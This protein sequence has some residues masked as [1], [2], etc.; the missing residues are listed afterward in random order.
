MESFFQGIRSRELTGLQVRKRPYIGDKASDFAVC[1]ALEVEHNG[2]ETP[3]LAIS[4][5]KSS[6]NSHVLAVSDEDGYLSLFDTRK[7]FPP[8]ASQ[9]EYSDK[10]R[11]S[12]WE[13][14]QNAIFD[15]CW[16]KEDTNLL[17]ASGD[18]TIKV[19]DAQK[20]KCTGVLMGHTGSIKSIYCHPTNSD[21]LV[22][23]SRDG[24]FAMWDLRCKNAS[25]NRRTEACI[26]PT[27]M[28]RRAHLSPQSKRVRRKKAASMSIT[29]V[30]YLKDGIS[31]ATAGAVDSIVKFWD[32]RYLKAQVTQACPR[33]KSSTGKERRL[34]GTSSLSQDS[35][36]VF[37]T[38][39]CMDNSIYL[40]NVLQLEKGPVRSFSG[41]RIESFYVKSEISPDAAQL[42]SGSSD[43]NAYIWQVN[44]PDTDPVTLKT[45]DGEVTAVNWCPLDGKIAT[46]SDDFTVRIWNIQSNYFSNSRSSSSIRRRIMALPTEECR[47]LL[48]NEEQMGLAKTPCSL[49]P[50]D[51]VCYEIDS[52]NSITMPSVFLLVATGGH[53]LTSY[54]ID[55]EM[56]RKKPEIFL[57]DF[58]VQSTYS[59]M[60]SWV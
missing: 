36:G 60:S 13:A 43:G 57:V 44:K 6:K 2:E 59:T 34:H 32:T 12:D 22:S 31:I 14:H 9:Q 7:N 37:L 35:N 33:P 15:I 10:S 5:A 23:G 25:K 48:R 26:T 17:T 58:F 50:S 41:C 24:S 1:G 16:I 3:P 20:Q 29:S 42:L 49:H 8:Y 53:F 54:W 51:E 11:I 28:I 30:L 18:Q 19:W 40:Y 21:L 55:V 56:Y 4:F 46:A 39:S 45:H 38:A 47:K 52:P 27:T